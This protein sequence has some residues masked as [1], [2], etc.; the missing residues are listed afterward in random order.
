MQFPSPGQGHKDV[1]ALSFTRNN[2]LM[3]IANIP[4]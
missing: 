2:T 3:L 4:L 1:A